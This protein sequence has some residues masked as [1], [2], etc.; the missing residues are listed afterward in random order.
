VD[1]VVQSIGSITRKQPSVL[2]KNNTKS[3]SMECI[4]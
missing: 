3:D 1:E 4:Q 2:K